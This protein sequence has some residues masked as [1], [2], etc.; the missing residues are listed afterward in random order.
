MRTKILVIGL[1]CILLGSFLLAQEKLKIKK[2]LKA[3]TEDGRKVLLKTD[4][5]WEFIKEEVKKEWREVVSWKGSATKNTETFHISSNEWIISWLTEPS[6]YGEM[7]FQIFVYKAN[8]EFVTLAANV[9]GKNEDHS[10]MRGKGN[11]Y[12]MI[13]SAQLYS[14]VILEKTK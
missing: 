1:I 2:D 14:V 8:G 12:L 3:T 11:Y 5:T 10:V 6:K 4:G 7:V 9:I 13:N